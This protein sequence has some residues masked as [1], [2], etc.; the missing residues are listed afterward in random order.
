MEANYYA[1]Q[2]LPLLRDRD[3]GETSVSST[4]L[5]FDLVYVF[6]VTQLSHMLL[7][8]LTWRGALNT[9]IMTLA[10]WWVWIDTAWITNWFDPLKL[11]IKFMLFALML[12]GLIMSAAIPEAFDGRGLIFALAFVGAQLG[13]TGFCVLTLGSNAQATNFKRIFSWYAFSAV[14]WLAGGFADG[15]TRLN[16][17]IVAVTIDCISPAIGFWT[18]GLGRSDTREWTISG[19]HLAE[20]CQL[21]V[22][23]C[24]G[25]SLLLTGSTL[26]SSDDIAT[27]NFA[28]FLTAFVL[29]VSMWWVYFARA[30]RSQ[31]LIRDSDDPGR[32]GRVFTYFHMP[33]VAGI[34]TLAA[35]NELVIAHPTGHIE[36]ATT[37]V[38]IAG[39]AIY[40]VGNALFNATLIESLPWR[41]LSALGALGVLA[42]IAHLMSPLA[43][44]V[45]VA[46]V[47]IGI[48]IAD[49]SGTTEVEPVISG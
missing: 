15:D 21:F 34:I 2:R 1:G 41:R 5:F 22:I 46:A 35:G 26:A 32:Y 17:W 45:G 23:I 12:L 37:V 38:V 28:A 39:A 4:E 47:F 19:E 40:I 31:E 6:A 33:M 13:R 7:D 49:Y 25:E 11:P 42:A 14:F 16:L 48:A 18:P 20:R 44:L 8:N 9:A 24:L 36:P 29:S 10:V 43:V 3:A 30:G 27:A